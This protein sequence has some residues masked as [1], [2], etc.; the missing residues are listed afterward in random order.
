MS[1]P[2]KS[3]YA[4]MWSRGGCHGRDS[5]QA[6]QYLYLSS[7]ENSRFPGLLSS[8]E[9]LRL[10]APEAE[11]WGLSWFDDMVVREQPNRQFAGTNNPTTLHVQRLVPFR[12]VTVTLGRSNHRQR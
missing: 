7:Q 2:W 10:L 11:M 12:P 8:A 3:I 6:A 9:E 5:A 1:H 4:D